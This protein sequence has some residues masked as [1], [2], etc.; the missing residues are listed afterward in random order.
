M[1]V[2]APYKEKAGSESIWLP[3]S[4]KLFVD[5]PEKIVWDGV[6]LQR[7][8]E[9]HVT[10]L[11]VK[12]VAALADASSAEAIDF[13]NTFVARKPIEFVSIFNDFRYAKES[14]KKVILVRCV[15]SHI[16]EL[17][18]ALNDT[19]DI[20]V[21]IQPPHVTLY[22]LQRDAGIHINSLDAMEH[23]ERVRLPQLDVAFTSLEIA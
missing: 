15:V 21:P 3:V 13:F 9:F 2:L 16:E 1:S 22:T 11:Q 8:S 23:L 19:F 17:F 10:L 4:E 7:K 6:S 20:N 5:F 14:E 18:A 12:N